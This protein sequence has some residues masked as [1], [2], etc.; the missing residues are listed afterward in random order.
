MPLYNPLPQLMNRPQGMQGLAMLGGALSNIQR[1]KQAKVQQQAT[2]QALGSLATYGMEDQEKAQAL[3]QLAE[4]NPQMFMQYQQM[5]NR[6]GG[7]LSA[8][9]QAQ[10]DSKKK[11]QELKMRIIGTLEQLNASE[12][13]DFEELSSLY[14]DLVVEHDAIPF[15]SSADK[16]KGSPA[17]QR[18]NEMAKEKRAIAEAERKAKRFRVDIEKAKGEISRAEDKHEKEMKLKDAQIIK[19]YKDNKLYNSNA[20]SQA[21]KDRGLSHPE[22]YDIRLSDAKTALDKDNIFTAV[23]TLSNIIEPGLSVTEGEVQGYLVGGDSKSK[24][25]LMDLF[26]STE[27]DA[28]E[29]YAL[30][31]DLVASRRA[32]AQNIVDNQGQYKTIKKTAQESKAQSEKTNRDPL[33]LGL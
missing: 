28:K 19:A 31:I 15:L 5:Q 7:Q 9:Q 26:G 22:M 1:Q 11:S 17:E 2:G 27:I 10:V 20:I 32:L 6:G 21:L 13:A 8:Y 33:G 14:N 24:K 30:M 18:A 3:S 25:I 29:L 4:A 23:K 16:W 12:G